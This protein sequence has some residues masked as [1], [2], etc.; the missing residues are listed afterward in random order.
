MSA[1]SK[2][3]LDYSCVLNVPLQTYNEDFYFIINNETFKT[4]RLTSD[5]LSPKISRIH[6]ADPTINR[7]TITTKHK[8]NFNRI[9]DLINF[10]SQDISEDEVTFILEVLDFLDNSSIHISVPPQ[11]AK[12]TLDNIISL[13]K[14]QE[15]HEKELESED[16]QK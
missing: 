4:N 12:I 2:M 14:Q 3:L 15:K 6:L 10:N 5:L 8:G 7:I 9:L 1:K 16:E 11:T 13:I